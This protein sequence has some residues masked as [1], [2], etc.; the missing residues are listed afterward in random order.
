MDLKAKVMRK[1]L[2]KPLSALAATPLGGWEV[3][4]GVR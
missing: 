1:I 4:S 3:A 2:S